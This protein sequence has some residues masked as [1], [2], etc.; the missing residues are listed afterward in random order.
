MRL[1]DKVAIVTGAARG[2]GRGIA[3]RFA[4]EG[5]RV[6]CADLQGPEE[7]AAAIV[8]LASPEAEMATG[9]V[10]DVNGGSYLRM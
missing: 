6:V 3:H 7:I 4:E 5:A 2:I 1:Q 9:A 8:F 10:L